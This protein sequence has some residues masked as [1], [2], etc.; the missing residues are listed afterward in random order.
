MT[1][2]QVEQLISAVKSLRPWL[3]AA[4]VLLVVIAGTLLVE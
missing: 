1:S 4:V 2:E 3:I